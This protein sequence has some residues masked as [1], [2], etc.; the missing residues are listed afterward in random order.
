MTQNICSII[1]IDMRK[2]QRKLLT[3]IATALL[4]ITSCSQFPF[5]GSPTATLIPTTTPVPTSTSTPAP[6]PT[7]STPRGT[8]KIWHAWDEPEVPALVEVIRM[9][10]Q[11]YPDILFD[12]LYVPVEALPARYEESTR[13]GWGPALL[14]GPAEWGPHLFDQGLLADISD[15]VDQQ[16]LDQI[17][18][19]ALGSVQ[20]QGAII[21]LPHAMDGVV[22]Y[23][24]QLI[25]PQPV[26]TFEELVTSAQAATSGEIIG[27]VLERSFFFSGGHLNGLGDK[28]MG[29]NYEPAFT[30]PS[31]LEWIRLLRSFERAGPTEY[32]SDNDIAL[33]RQNRAGIII[34][35]TW[36]RSDLAEAIGID[37]LAIDPWPTSEN[38][39][40]SG[41]VRS[42]NVYLSA[43]AAGNQRSASWLFMQYLLSPP[44]QNILA[45]VEHIPVVATVEVED[46]LIAEAMV[47]L[48][49]GTTYPPVP[50][51]EV[52]NVQ[53]DLALRAIFF[54]EIDPAAALQSAQDAIINQLSELQGQNNP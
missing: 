54:N 4:F 43:Q 40:L 26:L 15:L 48:A 42:D 53:M 12:V 21:G 27:A 1:D 9:F 11:Q 35:G 47:A 22:L 29:E 46:P 51:M 34:D 45:M 24:N 30:D 41:Y 38:G 52:Y 13:D 49:G 36:N 16:L 31:G 17:N 8:V 37:R 28:L 10:N 2:Y 18:P 5:S 23:R 14:L 20:Y 6:T 50:A 7:D 39:A 19:A 32:L 25:I 44:A 33:F 3:W